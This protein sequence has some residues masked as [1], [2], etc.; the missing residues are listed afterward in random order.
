MWCTKGSEGLGLFNFYNIHKEVKGRLNLWN[1]L[2]GLLLMLC[3]NLVFFLLTDD[4]YF[5]ICLHFY[6]LILIFSSPFAIWKH[7][8]WIIIL[9]VFVWMW[10]F[11]FHTKERAHVGVWEQGA[12]ENIWPKMQDVTGGWRNCII[13][14]FTTWELWSSYKFQTLS[15]KSHL[16][17]HRYCTQVT[18]KYLY[19]LFLKYYWDHFL[20]HYYYRLCN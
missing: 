7:K 13:K 9:L 15:S 20:L 12:E 19:N 3:I 6:H 16:D 4:F 8:D 10:S 1:V 14:R 18:L 17:N 2:F 11:D 5:N